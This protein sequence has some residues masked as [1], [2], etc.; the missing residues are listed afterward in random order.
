MVCVLIIRTMFVCLLHYKLAGDHNCSLLAVCFNV[1][2]VHGYVPVPQSRTK[3]VIYRIFLISA[4]L[5]WQP[6]CQKFWNILLNRLH[7][8]LITSDNQFGFKRRHSTLMPILILKELLKF[9]RDHGSTML[10]CFLDASKAVD[11]VDYSVLFRKLVDRKFPAYIMILL[12]N[13]YGYH[14][15]RIQWSGVLSDNFDICNGVRQGCVLSPILFGVYIDELSLCL[16]SVNIGC[17]LSN[18]LLIICYSLMMHFFA[19]SAKDLQ[20]LLDICSKFALSHNV[21]F[22]V[23]KSQCHHSQF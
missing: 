13:W 3:M 18:R 4:L 19:P 6:F 7:E 16:R 9:Y 5:L 23:V 1:M 11:R 21:V 22:N 14:F 8:Y 17:R 12:W 20:Q 10:V 15:A 2:F